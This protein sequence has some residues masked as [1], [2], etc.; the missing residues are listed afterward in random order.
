LLGALWMVGAVVAWTAYTVLAKRLAR[1]DHIV[2]IACISLLG[3]AML[4]P[5]AA[6]E[7]IA[8]RPSAPSIG[9]WGGAVFLGIAASAL[10]YIAYGYALR[11]LDASVVGVYTNLD[12]IVGVVT[13]V[14]FLGET[15][16][17]GQIFGGLVAFFGMWLASREASDEVMK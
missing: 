16:H 4:V 15:L 2:T 6:I 10:A 11:E 13:A 5:L 1:V 7:L 3:A 9:A 8:A 14:L 12:P 17:A